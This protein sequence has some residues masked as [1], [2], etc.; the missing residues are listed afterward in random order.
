[1]GI[2]DFQTFQKQAQPPGNGYQPARDGRREGNAI[3]FILAI[4]KQELDLL[5]ADAATFLLPLPNTYFIY[6]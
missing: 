5:K 4:G 3:K 1:M 6:Q 2:E